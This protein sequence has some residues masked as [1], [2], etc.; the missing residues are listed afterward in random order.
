MIAATQSGAGKTTISTALMAALAQKLKVQPFK[1]GPDYIDPSYHTLVT[2][3]I[4]RNLDSFLL[5]RE[6][7]LWVF[8]NNT[9]DADVAVVEG[10]MG[11]Y[12]GYSGIDDR[13]SSASVAKL[14]DIPVILVM[15]VKSAARS[16]AATLMGFQKFDPQVKIAG[17][18]LNKI[19]SLRHYQLV[20]DAIEHYCQVPVVGWVKKNSDIQ[21]P[22][23][24]LGLI[25]TS[26]G[27]K[28]KVLVNDI[29]PVMLE[30][31]DLEALTAIGYKAVGLPKPKTIERP[32]QN[33][34]KFRLAL[35]RD[36]AFSFYYQDGLDYLSSLGAEIVEFSPINDHRL[37]EDISGI[38]IGGG[39]PELFMEELS[40]NKAIQQ[41][42]LEKSRK[43]MPILA[44]CGGFM[45]L[46][47]GI[48]NFNGD[49]L[50]MAGLIPGRCTM[51]KKL[52]KM[53]YMVGKAL[54][55][56]I[57]INE[58]ETILGHEFHYS[59][60][61]PLTNQHSWALTL[62]KNASEEPHL[63]GYAEKNIFASYLHINLLG[64][65]EP[66]QNFAYKCIEYKSNNG[67]S[68]C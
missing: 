54:R 63:D 40:N 6:D 35:A 32:K 28:I 58:N 34:E 36:A 12:D 57:L 19:G 9:K 62:Q 8:Y 49:E 45:Y 18:I 16:A 21:V 29:L 15:D 44:E 47:R 43:G 50:P 13:G 14:L 52:V 65:K 61:Q 56:N 33:N 2:G 51:H 3:R 53:G 64:Q 37:P 31:I 68:S 20:K 67:G 10:V 66:A 55:N 41:D 48:I 23:R 5:S 7:L 22:E 27:E 38:Y 25:P 17:V 26:E 46:C 42:I 59:S 11:L 39:F 24:H 30:N 4:S 1:V 60:F